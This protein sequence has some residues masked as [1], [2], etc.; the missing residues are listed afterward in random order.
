MKKLSF[1]LCAA[2]AL[3]FVLSFS[4]RPPAGIH[5][6]ID[7]PKAAKTVWAISGTDSVSI[8]PANGMFSMELKPGAW[9]LL[10]EAVPPYQNKSIENI[11]VNED[12]YTDVGTI[13]LTKE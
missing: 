12:Q 4:Y 11:A 9:K 2:M 5:G 7:P 10:V 1:I 6:T 8:V 13:T 3:F